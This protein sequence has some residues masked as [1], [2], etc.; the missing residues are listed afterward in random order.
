LLFALLPIDLRRKLNLP[1]W[2]VLFLSLLRM[3]RVSA[4][5]GNDPVAYQTDQGQGAKKSESERA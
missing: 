3:D 1:A 4:T 2:I 5:S